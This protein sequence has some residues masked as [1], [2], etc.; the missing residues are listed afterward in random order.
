[1]NRALISKEQGIFYF[2]L[3][4]KK[5]YGILPNAFYIKAFSLRLTISLKL[6]KI[7]HILCGAVL[8][9]S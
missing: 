7:I 4:A 9:K 1:M 5:K 8:R 3:Q 2:N 6:D